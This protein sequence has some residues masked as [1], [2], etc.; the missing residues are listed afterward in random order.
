MSNANLA[1]TNISIFVTWKYLY[2]TLIFEAYNMLGTLK[3]CT[4]DGNIG[5]Y[6]KAFRARFMDRYEF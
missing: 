2:Q 5:D 4:F 1:V 3:N 6:P